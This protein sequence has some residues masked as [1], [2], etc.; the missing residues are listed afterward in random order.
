MALS[1][2]HD[3]TQS[4][5]EAARNYQIKLFENPQLLTGVIQESYLHVVDGNPTIGYG[6]DIDVNSAQDTLSSFNQ[7]GILL[8]QA[9]ITALQSYKN[10][11]LSQSE[12][13][14]AWSNV[15]VDDNTATN[16]LNTT[17]SAWEGGLS[18]ALS[19][20][21]DMPTSTERAAFISQLY[22]LSGSSSNS[23]ESNIPS[24]LAILRSTPSND[25]EAFLQRAEIWWEIAINS[26]SASQSQ[27]IRLG[28]QRRRFEE[29]DTYKI[30]A[31]P[32]DLT[33]QQRIDEAKFVYKFL[34][35]K[36]AAGDLTDRLVPAPSGENEAFLQ[37]TYQPAFDMLNEKYSFGQTIEDYRHVFVDGNIQMAP[38]DG[39]TLSEASTVFD[40]EVSFG[41]GD[42]QRDE[43][44]LIFMEGGDDTVIG[45]YGSD[46]IDGGEDDDTLSYTKLT[47]GVRISVHENASANASVIFS[48]TD[49]NDPT[50]WEDRFTNFETIIL[51]NQANVIEFAP[52]FYDLQI[53]GNYTIQAEDALEEGHLLDGSTLDEGF[54][55][56]LEE[57]DGSAGSIS[58]HGS[59]LT[60]ANFDN[61]T[62]SEHNDTISGG[63]GRNELRGGDGIDIIDGGDG[64]DEIHG[65]LGNDIITGG[66]GADFIYDRGADDGIREGESLDQYVNRVLTYDGEGNDTIGGGDGSDILVYSGGTDIYHGGKGNDIYMAT[67]RAEGSTA[68]T[69][70]LTI[71]LGDD[72]AD[73]GHDL[74]RGDGRFVEKVQFQGISK[75][76]VTVNYNFETVSLG[77]EVF[78]FNPIFS[79]WFWDP[80]PVVLDH[81]MTVGTIE[82]VVNG[83]ASLTI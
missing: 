35:A 9:E 48:A 70:S 6:W 55:I 23:I 62:G 79:N 65:G 4:E 13:L 17:V 69:D 81:Y 54:T 44:H 25:F 83:N 11:T 32:A 34:D 59:S 21:D 15:G 64:H 41:S 78:D 56:T 10:G 31:D 20:V 39:D 45:D 24:Q 68:A 77:T 46:Y 40:A 26:N 42:S 3:L 27:N 30:T 28:I 47:S 14:S 7:A 51:N 36:D 5:Y 1:N 73:F 49:V 75:D 12:F 57:S 67:D 76:D 63:S 80:E 19:S 66:A 2:Y 61:V 43:N 50:L 22:N 16:L 37:N 18:A 74:I 33:E 38:R 71:V 58:S 72:G 53:E 82:I 8:S 60:L 52:E 29:A